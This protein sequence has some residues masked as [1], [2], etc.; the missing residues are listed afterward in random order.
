MVRASHAHSLRIHHLF[1]FILHLF[2]FLF[3]GRFH[4]FISCN[5]QIEKRT[6]TKKTMAIINLVTKTPKHSKCTPNESQLKFLTMNSSCMCMC[7]EEAPL[8]LNDSRVL[9]VYVL[10]IRADV[11][12]DQTDFIHR[13]DVLNG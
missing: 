2:D 5:C 3:L 9:D 6:K 13:C 12:I 10:K 8:L 7:A 4:N 1:L 11:R